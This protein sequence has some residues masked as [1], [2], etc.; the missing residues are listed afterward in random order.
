MIKI[1]TAQPASA[2]E[3]AL[4]FDVHLPYVLPF[5]SGSCCQ[6]ELDQQQLRFLMSLQFS[7]N[8]QHSFPQSMNK[9]NFNR[10]LHEVLREGLF[11]LSVYNPET[12]LACPYYGYVE[13]LLRRFKECDDKFDYS[14]KIHSD[15]VSKG[16]S[17]SRPTL[18]VNFNIATALYILQEYYATYMPGEDNALGSVLGKAIEVGIAAIK[19][20]QKIELGN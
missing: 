13:S 7:V 18:R 16:H 15:V 14:G 10:A 9:E 1:S 3:N 12:D 5:Y 4:T 11:S 2:A 8:K 20:K 17:Y 6:V 19:R